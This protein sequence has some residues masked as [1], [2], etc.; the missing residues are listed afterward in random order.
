MMERVKDIF[1]R[2]AEA[3]KNI[4]VNGFYNDVVEAIYERVHRGKGKVI[5][6]GMGKAGQ[7]AHSIATTLSSTGTTAIFLHPSE[8]QHGDLGII[9]EN[10]IL[11][12]ISNSGRT[13]EILEL[14]GLVEE[15]HKGIPVI[16]LTGNRDSRL[17]ESADHL[18]LTGNPQEVCTLGLTPTTSTTVMAV[19]GDAVVVLLQEKIGFTKKDYAMRHHGGYLGQKSRGEF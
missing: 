8:A 16:V 2:E 12:V 9:Q 4:P 13:R 17:A 6:S 3:I 5:T 7:I 14:L 15:L 1:T 11:F 19:I 18:L 10:D